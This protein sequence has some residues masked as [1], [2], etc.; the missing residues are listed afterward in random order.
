N[1]ISSSMAS[2]VICLSIGR[3][4]NFS[5]AQ[6]GDLPSHTTKYSSPALTQKVFA[7]MRRVGKQFSGVETPL[8]EG[9]LVPQQ[10]V[11]DVDDLVADIVPTDDVA[12]DVP[13]AD[14][15]PTPPSPTPTTPPPP[16]ELPS[17]SQVIPTPPPSPIAQPS[18]PQQQQQPSQPTTISMDLL[19]NL[20]ET[21]STLTR[22]VKNLEQNKISQ[23]L[24]IIKH[25]KKVKKLEKKRKLTVSGLKRLR[26]G[27]I[28]DLDA[29]KDVT[30]E[31]VEVE[32][33]VEV[34]KDADVQGRLEKSQA[35]VYHID[36]EH[37]DKVLSMQDD[38][39]ELTELQK[40]IEG[41]TTAKLMTK[42][43]TTVTTTITAA[44]PITA[45]TITA[46]PKLKPLKKQ[47]QIEQDEAY[48]RELETELNKNIKWDDVIEQVQRKEKEDNVVLRYQA[49]KRKPQTEAQ[50][51]KNMV[52]YLKNMAGFKMDYFKG[53]SYD[54]IRPIFENYFNSNVAFLEKRKS[55]DDI[56]P[57]FKAKFNTNMEFLLKSKEQIEEEESR[58]LESINETPA[59]K[60]TKRE[61]ATPLARKFPVVDYKIIL[62]NNKPRYKIIKANG[63]HQLYESFITVL[64]NF[65]RDELET[66]WSIVKE[67]FSTSKPNNF[68][69]EYLLTTL[70]IMFGRPDGQDNVWK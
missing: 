4:F 15:E 58:A 23:A 30:L 44:A 31:E 33:N 13:T 3:K 61:E 59:Q 54:D 25:K 47:A 5:R 42:V 8:F 18:S 10:A 60:A 29:Y 57:I 11:V 35:K 28:A 14:V 43:V 26:K 27:I 70:R 36:L 37:A 9:M 67:R 69:N 6:V 22:I 62:L 64:K 20:L 17:A 1:E 40:V 51:R 24:E 49:L 38:E 50:A 55:Y 12:V 66:L 68:S 65:D 7:N 48:A 34:E 41:V 39:P 53:M 52:I 32:K 45:T 21:C 63:T 56:R 2:A 46:A 16:Q 19:N